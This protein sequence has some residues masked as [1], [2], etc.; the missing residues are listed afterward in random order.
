MEEYNKYNHNQEVGQT[1][2]QPVDQGRPVLDG[3]GVAPPQGQMPA[4]DQRIQYEGGYGG[5]VE[6]Q[7]TG[8]V[9]REL[10]DTGKGEVKRDLVEMPS[11]AV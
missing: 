11:R 3:S 5:P 6:I 8:T 4:Y 7:Q 10:G 9:Q 1:T 2:N